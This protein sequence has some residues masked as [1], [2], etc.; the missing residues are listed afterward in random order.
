MPYFPMRCGTAACY[1]KLCAITNCLHLNSFVSVFFTIRPHNGVTNHKRKCKC[2][3]PHFIVC[4]NRSH[5]R[6]LLQCTWRQ[7]TGGANKWRF[8]ED[9]LLTS[10]LWLVPIITQWQRVLLGTFVCSKYQLSKIVTL[11]AEF[12]HKLE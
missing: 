8:L 9:N 3:F 6:S 12:I 7:T 2:I 11:H 10:F 1:G 4:A 5:F